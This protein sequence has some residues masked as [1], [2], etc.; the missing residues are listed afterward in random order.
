VALLLIR[1]DRAWAG[2]TGYSLLLI[3]FICGHIVCQVL[4]SN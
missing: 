4:A 1:L 3:D 2:V